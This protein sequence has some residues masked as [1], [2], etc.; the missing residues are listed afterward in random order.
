MSWQSYYTPA[1][2]MFWQGHLD[3]P[4]DSCFYQHIELIDL[5]TRT[6]E[7]STGT[8]FAL[9]GFKS[10]EGARRAS[11][12]T[13][14]FEG[15]DF[16][17]QRLASL[18]IQKPQLKLYDIGNIE[19]ND[20]NL[21]ACQIALAEIIRLLQEKNIRPIVLGGGH[22]LAW[23]HFQG[24]AD[25]IS[26]QTRLG[27]I[28]FDSHMD[29]QPL[30]SETSAGSCSTS[31][32]QIAAECEKT[33]RH[34]DYN[35]IGIQHA[36]N[37]RQQ[38]EIAKKF[39]VKIILA[40]EMHQGLQEKCFDFVDRVIDQNDVI[41]FSLSLDVF[42]PAFAPG[43]GSIQPLGLD[44]WHIIPLVRQVAAS[45]KVISY[46]ISG[47]IPKYDIDQRTAKLAASLIYEIIHHH[48]EHQNIK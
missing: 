20:H 21:E 44:P 7:L 35:C 43:V 15:P 9:I 14:S 2:P 46:D 30:S 18:P 11:M 33:Q 19:C 13:G 25:F 5:K 26:P 4:A 17:R 36:G 27:I 23:G 41:Y 1:N 22:E 34:L 48:N 39:E 3:V 8:S 24:I 29:M 47:L 40:D 6:L 37:I 16:I 31:F 12:R 32:Y 45:N 38:F 10:D 42:S 28:N